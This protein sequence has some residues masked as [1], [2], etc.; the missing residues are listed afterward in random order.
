VASVTC[1]LRDDVAVVTVD[2][3]K[4]NAYSHELIDELLGALD[5]AESLRAPVVL[6]GRPGRF[7]AGFDLATMTSGNEP[8]RALLHR[9]AELLLRLFTFPAPLVIACTGHALAFGG[10]LLFTGDH[11]IGADGEFKIG[12]NETQ[13]GLARYRLSATGLEDVLFGRVVSPER[14]VA[15]GFLD[16]VVGSD[17]VVDRSMTYAAELADLHGPVVARTKLALRAPVVERITATLDED[18]ATLTKS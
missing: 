16:E 3:G 12:L 6:A 10:I 2:D 9:G 1:E 13:I 8:M 4:A 17:E 14:A 7:S 15:L 5:A 18:L 11:R